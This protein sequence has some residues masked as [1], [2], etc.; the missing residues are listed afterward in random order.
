MNSPHAPWATHAMRGFESYVQ[1]RIHARTN[2]PGSYYGIKNIDGTWEWY[3]PEYEIEGDLLDTWQTEN[4]VAQFRKT[5]IA[6]GKLRE[7]LNDALYEIKVL[8]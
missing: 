1:A 8:T 2:A 7:A 6:I 3:Y 5:R 4:P